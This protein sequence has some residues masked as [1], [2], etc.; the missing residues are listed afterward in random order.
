MLFRTRGPLTLAPAPY[1]ASGHPGPGAE[2]EVT[3][4]L[5]RIARGVGVGPCTH[6]VGWA[7]RAHHR[8]RGRHHGRPRHPVCPQHAAYQPQSGTPAIFSPP[9]M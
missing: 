5:R 7:P 3:A 9:W 2:D 6:T 1:V 4:A 8:C